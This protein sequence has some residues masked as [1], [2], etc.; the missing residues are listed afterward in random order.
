MTLDPEFSAPAQRLEA[1]IGQLPDAADIFSASM[2]LAELRSAHEKSQ[3]TRDSLDALSGQ[4]IDA[5]H[6]DVETIA[7]LLVD[8]RAAV[9]T[10]ADAVPRH[11]KRRRQASQLLARVAARAEWAA[12]LVNRLT[13]IQASRES[14]A[15]V[16]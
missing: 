2:A 4:L 5:Y 6:S 10:L 13:A 9:E 12:D 1:L 11:D 8:M 7:A 3:S 14:L 15:A 16:R